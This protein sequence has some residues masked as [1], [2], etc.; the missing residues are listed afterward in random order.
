M[1]LSINAD[2]FG[3]DGT[4]NDAVARAWSE[5]LIDSASLM[6][7]ATAFR[8]AAVM[9]KDLGIRTGVHVT[10]TCEKGY[11]LKY[12]PLT[13]HA[14]LR[15]RQFPDSMVEFREWITADRDVLVDE[16]DA[17]FRAVTDAG[18]DPQFFDSHVF[19]IPGRIMER[20]W[21][22]EYIANKYSIPFVDAMRNGSRVT[23]VPTIVGVKFPVGR[24]LAERAESISRI[25]HSV[26][27]HWL[28]LHLN[29]ENPRDPSRR[30]EFDALNQEEVR[31]S[32]NARRRR[33]GNASRLVHT[34][35]V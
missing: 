3:R 15:G 33:D 9:A 29:G 8:E 11:G 1:S 10:L 24:T 27:V 12:P 30:I 5:R 20:L 13:D 17:Q 25:L 14:C 23:S 26:R 6:A 34:S 19:S 31:R 4:T 16:V 2:D 7:P 28:A 32:I 35:D 22:V 18:L 21:L